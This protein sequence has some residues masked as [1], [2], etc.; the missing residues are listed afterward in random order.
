M[1]RASFESSARRG[2][3]AY[4]ESLPSS[5][6]GLRFD[7]DVRCAWRRT[8]FRRRC[9]GQNDIVRGH[10]TQGITSVLRGF[11]I[12]RVAGAQS[13]A[14]A[15]V[16]SHPMVTGTPLLVGDCEIRVDAGQARAEG[17]S[18]YQIAREILV[19]PGLARAYLM[20]KS[21]DFAQRVLDLDPAIDKF[22]ARMSRDT[23][24]REWTRLA[25]AFADFLEHLNEAERHHFRSQLA[26]V[27]RSYN[28]TDLA[29]EAER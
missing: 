19:D 24:D 2:E 5:E 18:L 4:S 26:E 12:A 1:W 25:I 28:R 16:A 14:R 8:P 3:L 29:A 20:T 7:V 6:P 17:P 10:V 13:A 9:T 27:F 21:P 11:P 23:P 15:W 22:V